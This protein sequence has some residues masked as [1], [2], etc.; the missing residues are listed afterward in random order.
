M[1]A[2]QIETL[3]WR[4]AI[5][6]GRRDSDLNV[7]FP[8]GGSAALLTLLSSRICGGEG[9]DTEGRRRSRFPRQGTR[10]D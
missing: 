7:T 3:S 10:S 5:D 4:V 8:E 2:R 9:S 1:G 6:L